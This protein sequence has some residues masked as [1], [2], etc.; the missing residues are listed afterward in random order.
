MKHTGLLCGSLLIFSFSFLASVAQQPMNPGAF[1]DSLQPKDSVADFFLSSS[2]GFPDVY[3]DTVKM[4]HD[5]C[6]TQADIALLRKELL[7]NR[8][9]EWQA[10]D[11]VWGATIIPQGEI[12]ELSRKGMAGWEKFRKKYGKG[13]YVYSIPVFSADGTKAVFAKSYHTS[14]KG[15]HGANYLYIKVKDKWR[16]SKTYSNWAG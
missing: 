3:E 14:G 13:F 2:N 10:G 5:T 15:T 12:S 4:F 6:F 8:T 9:R 7:D 1:V 16:I 11:N